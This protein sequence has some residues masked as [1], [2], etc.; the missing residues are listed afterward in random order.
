[1]PPLEDF[2]V[3][4]E[5]KGGGETE[6]PPLPLS[7]RAQPICLTEEWRDPTTERAGLRIPKQF[8]K[9]EKAPKSRR[10][11]FRISRYQITGCL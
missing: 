3:S 4:G 9:N 2:A 10:D 6:T 8:Q 7:M 11:R 1:M 5:D